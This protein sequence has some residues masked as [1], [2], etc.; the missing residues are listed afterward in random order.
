MA[1]SPEVTARARQPPLTGQCRR[2]DD[3]PHRPAPS[4]RHSDR[5]HTRRRQPLLTPHFIRGLDLFQG[6]AQMPRLP[7]RLAPAH[8]AQRLRSRLDERRVRR[9]RPRRVLAVLTPA[10]ASTRR[11]R[12]QAAR[13]AQPA[14]RPT[15]QGPHTTDVDRW[16]PHHQELVAE[17]NKPRR[18]PE[19]LP[20]HS[21]P[22]PTD[23]HDRRCGTE[24]QGS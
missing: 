13:S 22:S 21:C 18:G 7:S 14:T 17:I 5:H 11:P 3:E 19:R 9:R 1:L 23:Y 20:G 24:V 10:A 16:A 4:R 12:P 15:R 6:A 2:P 8:T